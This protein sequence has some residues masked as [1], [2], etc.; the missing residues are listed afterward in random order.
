[1]AFP[2][3]FKA[4]DYGKDAQKAAAVVRKQKKTL[5]VTPRV[6]AA[7][8][9]MVFEAQDR[10]DAAEAVGLSNHALRTALTKPHVLAYLNECQ[11]VLR[12]SARPRAL[13]Q[14][15]K[16][17]TKTTSER[18]QLDAAK[19]I[20]GMDRGAHQIGASMVNVQVNNNTK[21]ETPGY[22][23]DL[24]EFSRSVQPESGKQIDH[25][26]QHDAKSLEFNED[27]LDDE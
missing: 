15:I 27:V 21:I 3:R 7:I 23:I 18:V 19:Y 5:K 10:P 22:V 12:T 14:V 24:S 13:N 11:E 2:D 20:D 26:H 16:L 1:M 25:L 9:L 8:E 6:K 4:S 17:M